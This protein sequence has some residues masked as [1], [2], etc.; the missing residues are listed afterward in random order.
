LADDPAQRLAMNDFRA[1]S[2]P[3]PR[4]A[5]GFTLIELLVSIA[6]IAILIAI[7]MPAVQMARERARSAQCQSHLKQIGLALANY[8][9]TAQVYPPSFV[10][11]PDDQPPPPAVPFGALR[12]RGYWT[13]FHQLLPYLDQ[14]PLYNKFNFDGTWLSPVSNPADHS[15]WPANQT[16]VPVFVCPSATHSGAIG[17]DV[18][19]T[20]P[21]WMAGAPGDYAF[22][23]GADI[24]RDLAGDDA[25]PGGKI[26]YWSGYP[27]TTRGPFGYNSDC[28]TQHVKD[29]LSSTIFLGEKS[30]GLL[31]YAGW[32]STFP[33]LSVEYPWG[34]AAVEYLAPTGDIGQPNSF[35]VAG[36][37]AAMSDLKLPNCL[38]SPL[39]L[40]IPH[41]INPFPRDVPAVSDERP[42]YSFQSPHIGGAHFLFGDGRV[43]FLNQAIHQSVLISLGTIAGKDPVSDGDY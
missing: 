11:Q 38:D 42:F 33:K 24:H 25:C 4:R 7:T 39:A 16:K 13:G 21:H 12:Y 32:N 27:Q 3:I 10:R 18:A 36:P 26:P 6:V 2:S 14:Q 43:K 19:S 31:T 8:E 15:G 30:G 9:S 1:P 40:A 37:Y 5:A 20:P 29:G 28:R 35:W 22:S 23:H 34:M 17:G 41:P